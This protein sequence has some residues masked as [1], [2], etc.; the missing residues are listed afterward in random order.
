MQASLALRDLPH[1]PKSSSLFHNAVMSISHFI[2]EIGR[3]K[4]GARDLSREQAADLMG[5]VLD[6]KVSDMQLGAFCIAM[7]VKGETADEMAG[8]L[9]ATHQRLN[10]LSNLGG[11]PIVVLPSYNGSRRL[12]LLT[13]LLAL[14]LNQQGLRVL[15]HGGNTEDTRVSTADVMQALGLPV[16]NTMRPLQAHETAYV[17][18]EVLCPGLWQLLQVRRQIGLRNTGHSLVKLMNPI[19]GPSLLVASYT[20]PEYE[21]SMLQT[22]QMTQA[23]AM[24]LRG[25]EGEPVADPRRMRKS[26]LLL[27]GDIHET[28]DPQDQT[29]AEHAAY[30]MGLDVLAT[31]HY[32]RT[33]AQ[34]PNA[35]P[36]PLQQQVSLLCKLATAIR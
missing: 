29:S 11:S 13:P 27:G 34:T 28:H 26:V 18:T 30:P 21:A 19:A 35:V 14:L 4:H 7:R 9:D 12:P 22:L 16:L 3:G 6:G 8:C 25:T 5:Q 31:A 23:H 1:N 10:T 32:I 17:P 20:H 33:L 15:V 24:L 36:A 2:R